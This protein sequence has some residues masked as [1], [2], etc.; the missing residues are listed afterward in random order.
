MLERSVL[1]DNHAGYDAGGALAVIGGTATVS[2]TTISGNAAYGSGGGIF[3][4]QSSITISDSTISNNDAAYPDDTYGG[5]IAAFGNSSLVLRNSTVTGNAAYAFGDSLS[6]G[7]GVFADSTSRLD[8]A[9]SVVAGNKVVVEPGYGSALGPDIAGDVTLSNGHNVF[10]TDITGNIAGD[11]ESVAPGAIFAAIDPNTGGGLLNASGVVPLRND[12]ANPA[13]SG[14]DS[15]LVQSVDQLGSARFLPGPSRADVGAV[16]RDQT[17][18][19]TA[20]S[21]NNDVLTGNANANTFSALA[22]NDKLVGLAAADTLNGGDGSD[23]LDGG[24]GNDRLNGD[25]GVDIAVYTGSTALVLDLGGTTDTARR[26]GETDTL[27]GIEGALGSSAADTFRGD[28][29][30]NYFRG[31]A[32]KDTATGGGGRDLYDYNLVADSPVGTGRDV[33]ADFAPGIDDLDLAGVDADNTVA[34][35]QAFRFVGTAGL[36]TTP[37][38]VGYLVSGGNTVVRASTDA[39]G[40]AELAI[41]LTGL[42]TL[43]VE[44]FYL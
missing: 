28:A 16:E 18:L 1:S 38:A 26:S 11:R 43:T 6:L 32:G 37:G 25:A 34:G 42:K 7:G 35:D 9:N 29:L 15:L 33:I 2:R 10:G 41:Q 36:G 14:A 22:G 13:L 23:L 40:T 4:R 21:A 8:V 31:A 44:D 19:S 39:D 17:A 30:A 20:A 12:A 24:P 27:T 5:G 3:A